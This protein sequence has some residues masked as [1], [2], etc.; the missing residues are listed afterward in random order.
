MPDGHVAF[1]GDSRNPD[2]DLVGTPENKKPLRKTRH[3]WKNS[4][5]VDIN[6][7][8]SKTVDFIHLTQGR[9]QRAAFGCHKC[10]QLLDYL[11]TVSV[12]RKNFASWRE[13]VSQCANYFLL[14]VEHTFRQIW[15]LYLT[16]S[17][18]HPVTR[19]VSHGREY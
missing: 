1:R 19:S 15:P 16:P 14:L 2:S 5:T 17:Q 18:Q 12:S 10:V 13:A 8:G 7:E 3:M 6:E 9:H 11:A 4:I